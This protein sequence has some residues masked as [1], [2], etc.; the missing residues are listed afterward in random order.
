[1][2]MCYICLGFLRIVSNGWDFQTKV[3]IAFRCRA[4][5]NSCVGVNAKSFNFKWNQ[6]NCADTRLP[7]LS[8]MF[9]LD[10]KRIRNK[11][12]QHQHRYFN[13]YIRTRK[14][15]NCEMVK[16]MR[17]AFK[18]HINYTRWIRVSFKDRIHFRCVFVYGMVCYIEIHTHKSK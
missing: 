14:N 3:K 10:F 4:I 5:P 12:Q 2:W 15:V 18:F 6:S 1:M 16:R 8:W 7:I 13:E 17:L 11:W 9:Y